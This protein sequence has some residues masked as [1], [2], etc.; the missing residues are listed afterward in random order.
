M[1]RSRAVKRDRFGRFAGSGSAISVSRKR[2]MRKMRGPFKRL[3]QIF[4]EARRHDRAEMRRATRRSSSSEW[5][6]YKSETAFDQ[7]ATA[8]Q[9]GAGTPEFR[10]RHEAQLER[11]RRA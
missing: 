5:G 4:A 11:W 8:Y 1:A 2:Q 3:R 7:A 9:R 6:I 10:R